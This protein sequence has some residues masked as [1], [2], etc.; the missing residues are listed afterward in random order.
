MLHAILRHF[1][2]PLFP[3]YNTVKVTTSI[4]RLPAWSAAP[5]AYSRPRWDLQQVGAAHG[6]APPRAE[7]DA[8]PRPWLLPVRSLWPVTF[9]QRSCHQPSSLPLPRICHIFW[10]NLLPAG[11]FRGWV[12]GLGWTGRVTWISSSTSAHTQNLGSRAGNLCGIQLRASSKLLFPYISSYEEEYTAPSQTRVIP[13]KAE[14][15]LQCLIT[16]MQRE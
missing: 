15:S 16:N 12:K 14:A 11:G 2:T 3:S 13:F 7:L 1:P 9:L 5:K 8:Q 10:Q 4:F 6:W